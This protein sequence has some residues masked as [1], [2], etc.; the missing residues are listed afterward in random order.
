VDGDMKSAEERAY[1]AETKVAILR[2]ALMKIV[3]IDWLEY[4][5]D[6]DEIEEAQDIAKVALIECDHKDQTQ[7]QTEATALGQS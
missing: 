4:G 5:G 2:S 7:E 6:Y 1:I 3:D